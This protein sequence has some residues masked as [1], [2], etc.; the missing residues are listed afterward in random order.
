[1]STPTTHPTM[2]RVPAAT[3]R[4][5]RFDHWHCHGTLVRHQDGGAECS[6][7]DCPG[8]LALH[9]FEIGCVEFS[10]PCCAG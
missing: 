4:R 7:P 2:V 3:C 5:C 10:G 1:M 8:D 6:E 9:A